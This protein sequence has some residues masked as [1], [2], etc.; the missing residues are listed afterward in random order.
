MN[1]PKCVIFDFANTLS[2]SHFFCTK[3]ASCP[4]WYDLFQDK[5]F[6]SATKLTA[7][8]RGELNARHVAEIT[9]EQI[10]WSVDEILLEMEKGC[11]NLEFNNEVLLFARS[12][13]ANMI[14][15]GLVTNNIDLFT[16]F[17]VP[18]YGLDRIFDVIV[19]SADQHTDD[20]RI[21]WD[22][23]LKKLCGVVDYSNTLLIE[24]GEKWPAEF[25]K[26]GGTAYRYLNDAKFRTWLQ[27]VGY[28][29]IM[30]H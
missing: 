7:W 25:E 1:F 20:K 8:C 12:L 24:D 10:G 14:P 3:P 21:L 6:S 16:T 5:I 19:N 28:D 13:K 11:Q 27:E 9:Q 23:A 2:G 18:T 17:V 22:R 4:E 29:S 30:F 15:V 26:S